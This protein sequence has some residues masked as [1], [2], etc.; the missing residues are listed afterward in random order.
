[1]RSWPPADERWESFASNLAGR[2]GNDTVDV[3]VRDLLAGQTRLVSVAGGGGTGNSASG[4]AVISADGRYVAFQSGASDLVAGDRN[5]VE[6]IFVRD[7]QRGRT[8]LVS[9]GPD[10]RQLAGAAHAASMTADGRYVAFKADADGDEHPEV[11]LRDRSNRTTKLVLGAAGTPGADF[12]AITPTLSGD[13]RYLGFY[14]D[15]AGVVPRDTNR[16]FDVFRLDLRTGQ[17]LRVSVATG[18]HQASGDSNAVA[19]SHN[20]RFVAFASGA[21]DLVS[22]DSHNLRLDWDVFV[23]DMRTQVT[24][25][26]SVPRFGGDADGESGFFADL[27]ISADGRHVSFG[28]AATNLVR[29]DTNE[30]Y[31]VFVW[32]AP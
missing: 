29:R 15:A 2:D 22:G 17:T 30:G 26:V 27:S 19:L 28:S 24:R 21:Q 11:Y 8:E 3:F 31:D 4:E 9:M 25:R 12:E 16:A 32:D 14:T 20:G 1:M 6:D 7:V 10:G 13:G 5:A 23:R 18:G